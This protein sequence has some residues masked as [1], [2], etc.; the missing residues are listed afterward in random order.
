[1]ATLICWPSPFN[2]S[3]LNFD[4]RTPGEWIKLLCSIHS[5]QSTAR[6][7]DNG[8][9]VESSPPPDLTA[10]VLQDL[11]DVE[12]GSADEELISQVGGAIP[13]ELDLPTI[14]SLAE[15]TLSPKKG[16]EKNTFVRNQL[17][18]H[19]CSVHSD[20]EASPHSDSS[21]IISKSKKKATKSA[22]SCD[23]KRELRSVHFDSDMNSASEDELVSGTEHSFKQKPAL[24]FIKN[25]CSTPY[26]TTGSIK[27]SNKDDKSA[28]NS[29]PSHPSKLQCSSGSHAS[30]NC[31][32]CVVENKVTHSKHI[33]HALAQVVS[34]NLDTPAAP[35]ELQSTKFLAATLNFQP[36][37]FEFNANLFKTYA[38]HICIKRTVIETQIDSQSQS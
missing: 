12:K 4:N 22:L 34:S 7:D 32:S 17:L 10:E 35:L 3:G 6:I 11:S 20:Y 38:T 23:V 33:N 21:R 2:L 15:P 31:I 30:S 29:A 18:D 28:V 27:R 13:M 9:L 36:A 24:S 5:E 19:A 1:M 16:A 14:E 37:E 26:P 8:H 25:C